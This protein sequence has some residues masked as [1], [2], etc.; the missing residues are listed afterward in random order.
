MRQ[1]GGSLLRKKKRE[2]ERIVRCAE[3]MCWSAASFRGRQ[4]E[5]AVRRLAWLATV[6][7]VP[8]TTRRF[9]VS[10]ARARAFAK[11]HTYIYAEAARLRSLGTLER[12]PPLPPTSRVKD[13]RR[14]EGGGVGL[15]PSPMLLGCLIHREN[16]KD[17]RSG[18]ERQREREISLEV[19]KDRSSVF[20]VG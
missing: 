19:K 11:T 6:C 3:C 12:V 2:G 5:R 1:R 9:R 16:K 15:P 7:L 10:N 20:C 14:V 4:G 13:L 18:G 8:R 17:G